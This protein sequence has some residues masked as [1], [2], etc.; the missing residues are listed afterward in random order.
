MM[1]TLSVLPD[2][3]AVSRLEP[4]SPVPDWAWSGELV[5][6]SRTPDELSVLCAS[7]NVPD[8]L[9]SERDWAALKLH[10]PFDFALTGILVSV[11]EPLR[12]AGIGIFALSTFDTD[13]VLV[14]RANLK[15]AIQALEKAGH[16]VRK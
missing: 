11:L 2:E 16:D 6:V 13:Y 3:Y 4:H 8:G 15:T 7:S 1:L 14:K 10:G 12:V 5:S 9:R